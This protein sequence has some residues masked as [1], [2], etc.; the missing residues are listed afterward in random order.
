MS[1]DL[2]SCSFGSETDSENTVDAGE[3]SHYIGVRI[4]VLIVIR[5]LVGTV[6]RIVVDVRF[7]R[8]CHRNGHKAGSQKFAALVNVDAKSAGAT[9][10]IEFAE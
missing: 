7:L 3:C 2:G 8:R 4:I 5:I 10:E 1:Y 6:V 9:A